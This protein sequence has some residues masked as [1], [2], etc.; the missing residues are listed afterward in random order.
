MGSLAYIGGKGLGWWW[1][2]TFQEKAL[3]AL[4][5]FPSEEVRPHYTKTHVSPQRLETSFW[6]TVKGLPVTLAEAGL[7]DCQGVACYIS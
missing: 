2:H 7:V 1:V 5:A 3:S 4:F 6:W